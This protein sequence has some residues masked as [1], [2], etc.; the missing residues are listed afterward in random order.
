MVLLAAWILLVATGDDSIL[1]T[2]LNP[3]STRETETPTGPLDD[4]GGPLDK[5]G[6]ALD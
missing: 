2:D 6:G 5:S 3:D 4:S 1:P